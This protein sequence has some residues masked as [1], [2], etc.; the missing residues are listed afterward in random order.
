MSLSLRVC[1]NIIRIAV[2]GLYGNTTAYGPYTGGALSVVLFASA[3]GEVSTGCTFSA[4]LTR[5]PAGSY[6]LNMTDPIICPV[7]YRCPLGSSSPIACGG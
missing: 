3:G 7:A 4:V 1:Q 5:C 2:S 6:C